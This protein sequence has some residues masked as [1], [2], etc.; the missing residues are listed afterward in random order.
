[1]SHFSGEHLLDF[2]ISFLECE[3][4]LTIPRPGNVYNW[5]VHGVKSVNLFSRNPKS[6]GILFIIS[7]KKSYKIRVFK[8]SAKNP[9]FFPRFL[10]NSARNSF[11]RL[12]RW[13][14]ER[15]ERKAKNRISQFLQY[16]SSREISRTQGVV[17]RPFFRL[18]LFL[19]SS[20]EKSGV[21]KVR[22]DVECGDFL[23]NIQDFEYISLWK[24]TRNPTF[25][26]L[27][28]RNLEGKSCN[29]LVWTRSSL[30]SAPQR[31]NCSL[32]TQKQPLFWDKSNKNLTIRHLQ[33]AK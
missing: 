25:F 28:S 21:L 27:F 1:M 18:Q 7:D 4:G 29:S 31:R 32:K 6:L 10:D 5:R 9:T 26:L 22:F 12:P 33:R 17:Q 11:D 15:A 30:D 24:F 8:K 20:E 2:R 19:S 3:K 16:R 14:A 13:A 23:R